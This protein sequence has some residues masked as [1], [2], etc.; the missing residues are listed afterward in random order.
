MIFPTLIKLTVSVFSFKILIAI[1]YT[2]E[3]D[4]IGTID[5]YN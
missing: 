3:I 1:R 2:S 5:D 4:A